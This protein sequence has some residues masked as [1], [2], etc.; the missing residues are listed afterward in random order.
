MTAQL[1]QEREKKN[2]VHSLNIWNCSWASNRNT[3]ED[4]SF[5]HDRESVKARHSCC[6]IKRKLKNV[7]RNNARERNNEI[8]IALKNCI[9]LFFHT[10]TKSCKNI[11]SLSFVFVREIG[12]NFGSRSISSPLFFKATSF[13]YG[14]REN[15]FGCHMVKLTVTQQESHSKVRRILASIT[16][17]TF[18]SRTWI[19][20][21]IP[22]E[23]SRLECL[24]YKCT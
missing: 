18:L 7:S 16:F 17:N 21:L 9:L 19:F 10:E 5:S 11:F 8:L 23:L 3:P 15:F 2:H 14:M 6:S 20:P 24:Y 22:L 1:R 12:V 13:S 4:F